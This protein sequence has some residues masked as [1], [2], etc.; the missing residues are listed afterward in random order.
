MELSADEALCENNVEERKETSQ[1]AAEATF[2]SSLSLVSF[3]F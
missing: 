2:A 3:F 1:M